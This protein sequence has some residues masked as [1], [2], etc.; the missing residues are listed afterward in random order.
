[1]W[2]SFFHKKRG[3]K[4]KYNNEDF[5]QY[6]DKKK[7]KETG[8]IAV[9]LTTHITLYIVLLFFL[10][11]FAWYTGFSVTHRYYEVRGASMKPTYN[12]SISNTDDHSSHD[13]VYVNLY[14][15]IG[16][17]DAVVIGDVTLSNGQT[18][19]IIKR[20]IASEGDFVTIASYRSELFVYRILASDM[21]FDGDG[22]PVD[23]V[24]T[25]SSQVR[26]Y[27][28]SND[29]GYSISKED[30]NSTILGYDS[31]FYSK[32]L[33][34]TSN[35]VHQANYTYFTFDSLI[36]V[37][38]PENSYFCLGDN[39]GH[40]DDSRYF[41]FFDESQMAGRVEIVVYDYSFVNRVW[42]VIKFYYKEVEEFFA[43]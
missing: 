16:N 33:D 43:R 26:V 14:D 13:A 15:R 6:N 8:S 36:F 20:V 17:G 23:C 29:T 24:Y 19:N 9:Y 2:L 42:E 40:S 25:D 41:G 31:E 22:T 32:F 35:E 30:W 1:M 34:Q 5:I 7:K 38:V 28:N 21:I 12:A 10:I 27:E 3:D 37:Q 18:G 39:R 4:V 11:F